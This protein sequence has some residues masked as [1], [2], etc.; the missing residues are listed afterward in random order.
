MLSEALELARKNEVEGLPKMAAII[1]KRK[2]I[3]ATGLNSRKTHPMMQRFT[4]NHLKVCLHAE[5]AAITNALKT[6]TEKQLKGSQIF[7]ARVLKDGSRGIAKPCAVCQKALD[8]Y[9]ITSVYW[10]EYE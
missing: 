10:T 2:R 6:H 1:S 5:I 4:D 3:I 8:E 9:G 7:V